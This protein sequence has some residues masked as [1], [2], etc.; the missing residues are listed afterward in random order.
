LG[1]VW[2]EPTTTAA[3]EHMMQLI[4]SFRKANY[5]IHFASSAVQTKHSQDLSAF[6]VKTI[7]V[8]INDSDFDTM[9]GELQPDIVI[10]DR[11][12][13]EE[14]FSW[15]VA[16]HSPKSIRIL[17]TEDLH[18]LRKARRDALA[19]NLECTI[20]FWLRQKDT[21][22]ELASILRCDLSLILSKTEVKWLQEAGIIPDY[23][24]FYLPFMLDNIT[25]YNTNSYINYERRNNFIFVGQGKHAPNEDAVRFLKAD[26]WPL[27]RQ[28]L[29]EASLSIYGD[30]YAPKIQ[31]LHDP[32]SG[33]LLCGWKARLQDV[34]AKSRINLVP[35]RYG[36]GL[37]GKVISATA[38]GT[39]S[40]MTVVGAEG[41]IPAT[42]FDTC[43]ADT[44]EEFAAKAVA[45]YTD[46]AGWIDAQTAMKDIYNTEFDQAI[47][48][49]RLHKQ[50]KILLSSVEAMRQRNI[51][52][53]MLQHQSLNSQKYMSKW[54]EVKNKIG[55]SGVIS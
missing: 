42:G 23:L 32:A 21:L 39:P 54:I 9:I 43:L 25:D 50:L 2:P 46:E 20:S 36:S 29:P 55:K 34:M 45:L 14:Q 37:K 47:H 4:H 10:F 3:G 44:P 6:G 38:A 13:V 33:F 1:Q 28:K 8:E 52:G 35:L 5:K 24:L 51:V 7:R 19:A 53:R 49:D 31:E 16:E 40:M 27:I 15:R 11:F 18:S 48:H 12:M 17:N 26:I 41:I 22:R 30:G